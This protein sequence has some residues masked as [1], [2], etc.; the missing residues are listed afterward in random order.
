[1]FHTSIGHT[2]G[3]LRPVCLL[4]SDQAV[5]LVSAADRKRYK[6]KASATFREIDYIAV[7]RRQSLYIRLVTVE[8]GLGV[9]LKFP[10]F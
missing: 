7:R 1:M 3:D 4:I 9:V 10:T 6:K 5:Y 2:D 8:S